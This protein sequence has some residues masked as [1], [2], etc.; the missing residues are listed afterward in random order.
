MIKITVDEQVL[1]ALSKAMAGKTSKA[2]ALLNDYV[3]LLEDEIWGAMQRQTGVVQANKTCYYVDGERLLQK[4]G[5]TTIDGKRQ[6]LHSWLKDNKL[7]LIKTEVRG[8]NIT[9]QVSLVSLSS[10]TTVTDLVDDASNLVGMTDAEVDKYLD[11]D[12][13]QNAAIFAKMYP[14]CV[15]TATDEFLESTFDYV[16]VDAASLKNYIEFLVTEAKM[17]TTSKKQLYIRQ[18]KLILAVATHTNGL[19]IQRKKPSVF[20]RNY[21]AGLSVQNVN[22]E[23]RRAMLGDCWEY[24]VR[25]S[26]IAWKMGFAADYLQNAGLNVEVRRAFKTT[27]WYLEDKEEFMQQVIDCTFD[28]DNDFDKT[29]KVRKIKEAMTALS[30]GARLKSN[31]WR[32]DGGDWAKAALEEIIKDK[33]ERERFVKCVD[34]RDFVREQ[35][36]L[37]TYLYEVIANARPKLLKQPYL[38]TKTRPSKAKVIAYLYQNAET[39]NMRVA[40]EYLASKGYEVLAKIHD[41]FIVRD[42]LVNGLRAQVE[43]AMREASGNDYWKLGEKELKKYGAVNSAAKRDEAAHKQRIADEESAAGLG[44]KYKP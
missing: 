18:A 33:E 8:N 36:T 17:L 40:H 39:E 22:K 19:Y 20:G 16:Q 2:R 34:V 11:G 26:V 24:D 43:L 12:A 30:F 3:A 44:I 10:M 6:R 28:A 4:G 42:Q 38:R 23:L 13:K 31:G 41:A 15:D 25:S 5:Q 1:R 14:D 37:D 27:V 9:K 21:Y 7:A 35:N 32:L 29:Y